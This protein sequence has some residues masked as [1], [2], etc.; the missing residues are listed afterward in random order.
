MRRRVARAFSRVLLWLLTTPWTLRVLR[1]GP[2]AFRAWQTLAGALRAGV[3]WVLGIPRSVLRYPFTW[4]ALLYWQRG[5]LGFFEK[6]VHVDSV[7]ARK[8]ALAATL[9][10]L[11][12]GHLPPAATVHLALPAV[13]GYLAAAFVVAGILAWCNVPGVAGVWERRVAG[14]YRDGH[15]AFLT[16]AVARTAR[17]KGHRRGRTLPGNPGATWGAI[18]ANMVRVETLWTPQIPSLTFLARDPD[19]PVRRLP[20]QRVLEEPVLRAWAFARHARAHRWSRPRFALTL[21]ATSFWRSLFWWGPRMTLHLMVGAIVHP[22]GVASTF[23]GI[24]GRYTLVTAEMAVTLALGGVGGLDGLRAWRATVT[25]A[26]QGVPAAQGFAAVQAA[27]AAQSG[28]GAG[29]APGPPE[30]PGASASKGPEAPALTG[31]MK[32]LAAVVP[33]A[34]CDGAL[35]E[36]ARRNGESTALVPYVDYLEERPGRTFPEVHP[37]RSLD[38]PHRDD[39]FAERGLVAWAA[40][41]FHDADLDRWAWAEIDRRMRLARWREDMSRFLLLTW[42]RHGVI[43]RGGGGVTPDPAGAGAGTLGGWF[44]GLGWLRFPRGLAETVAVGEPLA[45][46]EVLDASATVHPGA[47]LPDADAPA[48]AWAWFRRPW[49]SSWRALTQGW[50][51]IA[52]GAQAVWCGLQG[53]ARGA[54]SAV[55]GAV[56]A[57]GGWVGGWFPPS[58]ARP[59]VDATPEPAAHAVA[60]P[61]AAPLTGEA[62]ALAAGERAAA[63]YV[64]LAEAVEAASA[65]RLT[66]E[67]IALAAGE[68]AAGRMAHAV[69]LSEALEARLARSAAAGRGGAAA[70]PRGPEAGPAGPAAGPAGAEALGAGGP[71]APVAGAVGPRTGAP[72]ALAGRED[73][74]ALVARPIGPVG[75]ETVGRPPEA[76]LEGGPQAQG[77]ATP[78]QWA[79]QDVETLRLRNTLSLNALSWL[80]RLNAPAE[81]GADRPLFAHGAYREAL[82][83]RDQVRANPA[84]WDGIDWATACRI[85]QHFDAGPARD[86]TRW[87]FGADAVAIDRS[88]RATG[89]LRGTGEHPRLHLRGL[90]DGFAAVL[91]TPGRYL[92]PITRSDIHFARQALAGDLPFPASRLLPAGFEPELEAYVAWRAARAQ[93]EADAEARA[94]AQAEARAQAKADRGGKKKGKGAA[95]AAAPKARTVVGDEAF[96][97]RGGVMDLPRRFGWTGRAWVRVVPTTAT[98]TLSPAVYAY[99][100]E[101]VVALWAERVWNEA[102]AI[103]AADPGDAEVQA[104]FPAM[105]TEHEDTER[106]IWAMTVV[107]ARQMAT[108]DVAHLVSPRPRRQAEGMAFVDLPVTRQVELAVRV[109][110]AQN[111]HILGCYADALVANVRGL[112]Q[113]TRDGATFVAPLA[114]SSG[115]AGG[116]DAAARAKAAAEAGGPSDAGTEAG[117]RASTPDAPRGG[118]A[119][120]GALAAE[121]AAA[122]LREDGEI[123]DDLRAQVPGAPDRGAFA[124][125]PGAI[126]SRIN[127]VEAMMRSH[128]AGLPLTRLAAQ[129][130]ARGREAVQ[131]AEGAEGAVR[132]A[133][134][135]APWV[136]GGLE[137]TIGGAATPT[138][139]TLPYGVTQRA[140]GLEG[141]RLTVG[142]RAWAWLHATS[143]RLREAGAALGHRALAIL[144]WNRRW[145]V[146]VVTRQAPQDAQRPG[147]APFAPVVD[148]RAAGDP[149]TEV[150]D[151][152][153][154]ATPRVSGATGVDPLV[155]TETSPW[156]RRGGP[157]PDRGLWDPAYTPPG[158]GALRAFLPEPTHAPNAWASDE[159]PARAPAGASEGALA[160]GASEGASEGAP[161]GAPEGA[162][163]GGAEGAPEGAPEG[164]AEGGEVARRRDKALQ[165]AVLAAMTEGA[166][167]G[168]PVADRGRAV[169][170]G[171]VTFLARGCHTLEETNLPAFIQRWVDTGQIP[172]LTIVKLATNRLASQRLPAVNPCAPALGATP[173]ELLPD[174][175]REQILLLTPGGLHRGGMTPELQAVLLRALGPGV[176]VHGDH[177]VGWPMPRGRGALGVG[178]P[179]PAG[180]VPEAGVAEGDPAEVFAAALVRWG[181]LQ[182]HVRVGATVVDPREAQRLRVPVGDLET[183]PHGFVGSDDA[184]EPDPVTRAVARW[185]VQV[186][187]A[188]AWA[189]DGHATP[190]QTWLPLERAKVFRAIVHHVLVPMGQVLHPEERS[191]TLVWIARVWEAIN[192]YRQPIGLDALPGAG[193]QDTGRDDQTGLEEQ[194]RA[195]VDG[196]A[197]LTVARDPAAHPLH[198][199]HARAAQVLGIQERL[200]REAAWADPVLAAELISAAIRVAGVPGEATLEGREAF[201]AAAEAAVTAATADARGALTRAQAAADDVDG[202]LGRYAALAQAH[203]DVRA[204]QTAR[205]A[206][207]RAANVALTALTPLQANVKD[208]ERRLAQGTYAWNEARALEEAARARVQDRLQIV[209]GVPRIQIRPNATYQE[210]QDNAAYIGLFQ[211]A[212]SVHRALGQCERERDRWKE[213]LVTA[214]ARYEG[215]ALS[216]ERT[217][218]AAEAAAEAR[219][220]AALGAEDLAHAG[221][222]EADGEGAVTPAGAAAFRA[223]AAWALAEAQAAAAA[224]EAEADAVHRAPVRAMDAR[225]ALGDGSFAGG[226]HLRLQ[227]WRTLLGLN[228][229]QYDAEFL[230]TADAVDAVDANGRRLE[231]LLAGLAPGGARGATDLILL[232]SPE[233]L[234]QQAAEVASRWDALMRGPTSRRREALAPRLPDGVTSLKAG[235]WTPAQRAAIEARWTARALHALRTGPGVWG[236][237]RR[238]RVAA[239]LEAMTARV[240]VLAQAQAIR[241]TLARHQATMAAIHIIGQAPAPGDPTATG[242]MAVAWYRALEASSRAFT[243]Y[244]MAC[245]RHARAWDAPAWAGMPAG[246]RRLADVA[247]PAAARWAPAGWMPVAE[248]THPLP[249]Y[250]STVD[251]R[252]PVAVEAGGPEDR[253]PATVANRAPQ[254]FVLHRGLPEVDPVQSALYPARAFRIPRYAAIDLVPVAPARAVG[255]GE[256]VRTPAEGPEGAPEGAEGATRRLPEARGDLSARARAVEAGARAAERTPGGRWRALHGL[257]ATAAIVTRASLLGQ[258]AGLLPDW[259][260]TLDAQREALDASG[261][262]RAAVATYGA[263]GAEVAADLARSQAQAPAAQEEA[264]KEAPARAEALSAA[265]EAVERVVTEAWTRTTGAEADRAAREAA[266]AVLRAGPA[267]LHATVRAT[268]PGG[269]G[270]DR[271]YGAHVRAWRA[272]I[273][274]VRVTFDRDQTQAGRTPEPSGMG[275]TLR[276]LAGIPDLERYHGALTRRVMAQ[277]WADEDAVAA[278]LVALRDGVVPPEVEGARALQAQNRAALAAAP[279]DAAILAAIE[280]LPAPTGAFALDR[281]V[282][283]GAPRPGRAVVPEE[284]IQRLASDAMGW[285]EMDAQRVYL[286]QGLDRLGGGHPFGHPP[287]PVRP[288]TGPDS[289]ALG[290]ATQAVAKA[291][292][293][294]TAAAAGVRPGR[295]RRGPSRPTEPVGLGEVTARRVPRD[296]AEAAAARRARQGTVTRALGAPSRSVAAASVPGSSVGSSVE[297]G[298]AA[299]VREEAARASEAVAEARAGRSEA[300]ARAAAAAEARVA[301]QVAASQ[302]AAA[303]RAA[304]EASDAALAAQVAAAA[305]AALEASDAALAARAADAAEAAAKAAPPKAAP[306]K[307]AGLAKGFLAKPRPKAAALSIREP[308][309]TAAAGPDVKGQ[310]VGAPDVKGKGKAVAEPDVKGKGKAVVEYV[311]GADDEDRRAAI[312][313]QVALDAALAQQLLAEDQEALEGWTRPAIVVGS[314]P[315]PGGIGLTAILPSPLGR[316]DEAGPSTARASGSGASGSGASGS[317]ASGSGA[318]GSGASGS[319]GS[320]PSGSG[321]SGSGP[322]GSGPSGSG[323]SGSGPSGSGPSGSGPS[324]SGPSGSDPSGS[325]AGGGQGPSTAPR[326]FAASVREQDD[327][328]P[329]GVKASLVPEATALAIAKERARRM[330]RYRPTKDERRRAAVAAERRDT[331]VMWVWRRLAWA[332]LPR[333]GWGGDFAWEL[334]SG[335]RALPKGVPAPPGEGY[336]DMPRLGPGVVARAVLRAFR[337]LRGGAVGAWGALTTGLRAWAARAPWRAA[338]ARDGSRARHARDARPRRGRRR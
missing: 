309:G 119:P 55:G 203:A 274:S 182:A 65:R 307:G 34:H 275:G 128:R 113:A 183:D 168:T 170:D 243:R 282:D 105:G 87:T 126:A 163:E 134:A 158:N 104:L 115:D 149:L 240:D 153:I 217:R 244:V 86:H 151:A 188:T 46:Q 215:A 45:S 187:P 294:A 211:R 54:W 320:G 137:G 270:A 227:R 83:F 321:P 290:R 241:G 317:G 22:M 35:D 304:Q 181:V 62:L 76:T 106:R 125:N 180:G 246:V 72:R 78:L 140:L 314:E 173:R 116:A 141:A 52:G 14:P 123:R 157:R 96:P 237:L 262:V 146:D 94:Q 161:E 250:R 36:A 85:V 169:V 265:R 171:L 56:R 79:I 256:E 59:P 305:R 186:R 138:P 98:G 334:W 204:T 239:Y 142:A 148:S 10:A 64:A 313:A 51:G 162:S 288:G 17:L 258:V 278:N 226:D 28:A 184:P 205:A 206:A 49:A 40:P 279:T 200:Q 90:A 298:P 2:R 271:S 176:Q 164:G 12:G 145:T 259:N 263:M 118:E 212:R 285:V 130:L 135:A 311:T 71:Q 11:E 319:G 323:P 329:F 152:L 81:P 84:L 174:T 235:A 27:Y 257:D 179:L 154:H 117:L 122:W 159:V 29:A 327:G 175:L 42:Q 185:L 120:E 66:P 264:R 195:P 114:P 25:H 108:P 32:V 60:A 3:Q 318:S 165:Q 31:A 9:A 247:L 326:F 273:A 124:Q 229:A 110:T 277:S 199:A 266:R 280:R 255:A 293:A 201:R 336:H 238:D 196:D 299:L 7:R 308:K 225:Q 218:A 26:T 221:L 295:P 208:V 224:A 97:D 190:I 233:E 88:L 269:P 80:P 197:W 147:A 155:P 316:G 249:I 16:M 284:A 286:H 213:Q 322:S 331:W 315:A 74:E 220:A 68:R 251:P 194:A 231:T 242:P 289:E 47:H 245:E 111:R 167:L 23:L 297:G 312:A 301:P 44:S 6:T 129:A 177:L 92:A 209:D 337:V 63:A 178:T 8:E 191:Q 144:D 73:R 236:D 133:T 5:W 222:L 48:S 37:R 102:R 193:T 324:G 292:K 172:T 61:T 330:G 38:Y 127:P 91:F 15:R 254:R 234:A 332:L 335:P 267:P 230:A 219:D 112:R 93:A 276:P 310:G 57:V 1:H 207:Q 281:D 100:E 150:N 109:N 70:G 39:V 166:T 268:V 189:V 325:G 20:V 30:A 101:H 303:A 333:L 67:E 160:E 75:P 253:D 107:L 302:A 58:A 300:T 82:T 296:A 43:P 18:L 89:A 50:R 306:A 21:V 139:A 69:A 95:K 287:A 198:P 328:G 131:R 13:L 143:V 260:R 283:G 4:A 77:E 272:L 192:V 41:G 99:A 228:T 53:G 338:D 202:V 121:V 136:P 223:A 291:S 24:V 214:Q 248:E 261:P 216:V 210:G 132:P 232:Y 33:V 156:A 19:H 252:R 103:H